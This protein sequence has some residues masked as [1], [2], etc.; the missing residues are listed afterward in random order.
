LSN[1]REACPQ[2]AVRETLER[3][4]NAPAFRGSRYL[5]SALQEVTLTCVHPSRQMR[6]LA[7]QDEAVGRERPLLF[8]GPVVW[9]T[10]EQGAEVWSS[11]HSS[12]G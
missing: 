11:C 9:L 12:R 7:R 8:Q 3:N 4:R 1:V 5:A 6:M 10:P 2:P